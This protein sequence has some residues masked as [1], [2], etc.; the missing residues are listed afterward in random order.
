MSRGAQRLIATLRDATDWLSGDDLGLRLGVS[1]RSVRTYVAQANQASDMPV[2]AASD[3][4]Y[5]LTDAGRTL[6][7]TSAEPHSERQT[8]CLRMG[9]IL[10]RDGSVD[11]HELAETEHVS[12]STIEH[13]IGSLRERWKKADLSLVRHGAQVTIEGEEPAVRSEFAAMLNELAGE[14]Q[15]AG[16]LAVAEFGLMDSRSFSLDLTRALE[17]N[18]Y[19]V[20]ELALPAVMLDFVVSLARSGRGCVLDASRRQDEWADASFFGDLVARLTKRH[21]GV[22][23]PDVERDDFAVKVRTQLATPRQANVAREY[24]E[25]H[26][27]TVR[28]IVRDAAAHYSVD[29]DDHAF[30][31]RITAH[32]A[33]VRQRNL[34]ATTQ[35]NPLTQSIK[36]AYPL[37][38]DIAVYVARGV[39]QSFG[40]EL[41]DDEIAYLALHVGT[42]LERDAQGDAPLS[43]TLACPNYYGMHEVLR[44]R[45]EDALSP[46]LNVTAVVS[47]SGLDWEQAETDLIVTTVAPSRY[48]ERIVMVQPFLNDR[49][50]ERVRQAMRHVRSQSERVQT[51]SRLESYLHPKLFTRDPKSVRN[52]EDAIR[53][54]SSLMEA[55]GLVNSAHADEV[56][57][58]ERLSSTEFSAGVAVPHSLSMGAKRT[59][60]GFLLSDRGL[61]WSGSTVHVVALVAFAT[62]DREVFQEVFGQLVRVFSEPGL[63]TTLLQR[64]SDFSSLLDVLA[65]RIDATEKE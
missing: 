33:N 58:R 36:T 38:Y 43:C 27:E 59:A 2:V 5:R 35:V 54:L 40:L 4:G 47:G 63:V 3:R 6:L 31:E 28:S 42:V 46:A 55:Q 17:A 10:L 14:A 60:I 15:A 44:A 18:G 51:K 29:L 8:R 34:D 41:D 30:L 56:L 57:E 48:R 32:L 20:N 9:I 37:V 45:L 50:V 7:L 25:G 23:L 13:D 62:E 39:Q 1:S 24:P 11:V 19:L 49:D 16:D 22:H 53:L 21:I 65:E 61:A 52:A 26:Q 12:D 64:V